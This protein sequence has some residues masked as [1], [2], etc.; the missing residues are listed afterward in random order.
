MTIISAN[1]PT[2]SS[3]SEAIACGDAPLGR[4][5]P[6]EVRLAASETDVEAALAL[7]LKVFRQEA[8]GETAS[9]RDAFDAYCDHLIVTDTEAPGRPVV[10]TYRLLPDERLASAGAFYSQGEFDIASLL[11]RKPELRFLEFGRSCVLPPY[12]DKRTVELLWHGAWAYVRRHGHDVMFGCASFPG[13]DPRAHEAG[14]AFLSRHACADAGWQ[15]PAQPGRGVPLSAMREDP[16][17]HSGRRALRS[18]PAMIKGYMRL[19]ARFA[20]EAVVDH[21]FGTVDVLVI[22]PVSSL[23]PRYVAY[24]GADAG[25]HAV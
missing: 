21:D 1:D 13:T 10:A 19:G 22:M 15:V 16:D 3:A 20:A 14:L 18:L 6:L 2:F 11:A 9:D 4:I 7:R 8:T 17:D 23:N 12:R 25:R 5:G 24:Y